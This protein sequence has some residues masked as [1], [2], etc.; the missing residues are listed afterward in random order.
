MFRILHVGDW[1]PGQVVSIT[2]PNSRALI[3]A[4]EAAVEEAWARALARPGVLLFDGPMCRLQSWSAADRPL[5]LRLAPSSYKSFFGTNI[6]HP[7]FAARYGPDVMA[8]P[9]GVSPTL[10]TSDGWLLMGRRNASVAYYPGRVHPFAGCLEPGDTDVFAAV[11]RELAEELS[12]APSEITGL[13]CTGLIYETS[14]NQTE[15]IFAA[16]VS[17]TRDQL[18]ARL[19]AAEHSSVWSTAAD[20]GTV[21]GVVT[22]PDALL[23]PIAIAALLLDGRVRFGDDWFEALATPFV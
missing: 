9:L 1:T 19:D 7:E 2:E 6:T 21:A 20:A 8:N 23:T 4:V 10:R 12:L 16:T 15:L 11:E 22:S 18:I 5:T 3:P 14:L 17:P 13:R